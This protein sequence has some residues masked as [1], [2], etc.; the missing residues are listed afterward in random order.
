MSSSSQIDIAVVGAGMG[1]LAA[2]SALLRLGLEVEVYEQAGQFARVGAG[3]HVAPNAVKALLGLGMSRDVLATKAYARTAARHRNGYTGELLSEWPTPEAE[4][5]APYTTWHR[6]DLHAVMAGLV[7]AERVHRGRQLVGIDRGAT[8]ATLRFADGSTVVADVVIA[9]D[10]I[11]SVIRQRELGGEHPSPTGRSAYRAVIARDRLPASL[12]PTCKWWGDDRHFVHYFVSGGREVAFTTS[13][14]EPDWIVESW[15]EEGDVEHLREEFSMFHSDVQA[16]LGAVERVYRWAIH[17]RDP[18]PSWT[19]GPVVLIG[20]ACHP[21]APYMGQGAAMAI[22]DAI[23]LAR[24][25]A[26]A[27]GRDGVAEALRRFEQLRKPRTSRVQST[28]DGNTWGRG[29]WDADWLFGYDAWTVPL[30]LVT[31]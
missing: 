9:A 8:S 14:H 12:D 23:V 22:E 26:V 15:S 16:I 6:G 2:A 17:T 28:S 25:L 24:C 27:G 20:D 1:G 3:I 30:D 31:A 5:G 21:M 7:P 29:R 4:F 19:S 10:G 18:L 11:H 13:L